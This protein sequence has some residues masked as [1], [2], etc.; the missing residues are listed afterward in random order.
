MHM[1]LQVPGVVN[2]Y[3]EMNLTCI[4]LLLP[5]DTL[6]VSNLCDFNWPGVKYV[7]AFCWDNTCEA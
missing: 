6:F 7:S 1:H 3:Y 4:M 2:T 5:H